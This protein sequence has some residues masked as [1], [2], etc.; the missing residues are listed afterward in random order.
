MA[1]C[2]NQRKVQNKE[3]QGNSGNKKPSSKNKRNPNKS[4]QKREF[5]FFGHEAL[6]KNNR[7]TYGRIVEQIIFKIQKTF[8][9]PTGFVVVDS[10]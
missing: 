8:E 2:N 5:K 9:G 1:G 10:L 7:Y 3:N 4:F 6:K